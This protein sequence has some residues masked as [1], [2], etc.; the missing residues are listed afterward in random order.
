CRIVNRKLYYFREN[1]FLYGKFVISYPLMLKN[2]SCISSEEV[3]YNFAYDPSGN[4]LGSRMIPGLINNIPLIFSSY[5]TV[6]WQQQIMTYPT[7][8]ARYS[9]FIKE[10]LISN[11]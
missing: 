1:L 9:N 5:T 7:S 6:E 2:S 10:L 11:K 8:W 4:C 3:Q